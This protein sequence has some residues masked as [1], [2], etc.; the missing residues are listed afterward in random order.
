MTSAP[1][2]GCSRWRT[3]PEI[4]GA[5][6]GAATAIALAPKSGRTAARM[7][8]ALRRIVGPEGPV[9]SIEFLEV[10]S[11]SPRSL[12]RGVLSGH[13]G[14]RYVRTRWRSSPPENALHNVARDGRV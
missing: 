11:Y 8:L 4:G 2:M 7:V 9:G 14:S 10:N 6:G 5:G 3:T 1:A 12:P 13:P